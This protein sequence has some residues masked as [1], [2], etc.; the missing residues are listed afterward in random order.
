VD[1]GVSA[2]ISDSETCVLKC[3]DSDLKPVEYIADELIKRTRALQAD[4]KSGTLTTKEKLLSW[5]PPFVA[6]E[7]GWY[8]LLCQQHSGHC[9]NTEL[10]SGWCC[11][12]G[13][14]SFLGSQLGLSIPV[15]G[16]VPFP[17]GVAT[18]IT[19]PNASGDADIDIALI[20]NNTIDATS[21]PITVTIGGIRVLATID[22][23]RKLH[24]SHALN[25]CVT[26][27]TRAG[28][29][30]ETRRFC[31]KLQSYMN[32]P[33]LLDRDDRRQPAPKS[34]SASSADGHTAAASVVNSKATAQQL[35]NV[36]AKKRVTIAKS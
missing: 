34:A 5:L 25:V 7:A 12:E 32:D 17:L 3:E 19:S 24:A 20:P 28:S 29:L 9:S 13:M 16:V 30:I 21:T 31:S 22:A 2:D 15:L 11:S 4:R 35:E 6:A 23:D 1:I 18:I 8:H 27:D 10:E 26:V 14:L 33:F 36:T